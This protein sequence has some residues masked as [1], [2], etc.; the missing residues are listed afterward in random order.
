MKSELLPIIAILTVSLALS[1]CSTSSSAETERTN[2]SSMSASNKSDPGDSEPS[3]VSEDRESSRLEIKDAARPFD[4]II[5]AGQPTPEQFEKLDDAGVQTVINFRSPEEKGTWDEETKAEK[6]GLTYVNIVV[7]GPDDLTRDKV[8]LFSDVLRKEDGD[9]LVHCGSS[10]RV[11]AMFALRAH[12]FGEANPE[13]AM[14][15]GQRA[16]L[17]SLEEA[18]RSKI[19]KT[20]NGE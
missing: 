10:N 4:G 19:D 6:M 8:D 14:K 5:T 3:T 2:S 1:A 11:G 17:D 13:E 18:V 12:W 7:A 20:R 15:I 9:F 16:G